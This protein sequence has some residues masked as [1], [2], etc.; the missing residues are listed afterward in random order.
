[1]RKERPILFNPQMVFAIISDRKTQTRRVA[2]LGEI[3][4]YP[5]TFVY[6]GNSRDID[7]AHP[8]KKY[9]TSP[10]FLLHHKNSNMISHIFQCPFGQIGD[11]LWVREVHYKYGHWEKNGK[12]KTGRQKWKFVADRS[13]IMY[14]DNPPSLF[15]KSRNKN[16]PEKTMCYKRL[17]RFMSKKDCRIRLKISQT[18]LERIRSIS[19][20]D[21]KSEGVY[22]APHRPSTCGEKLHSDKSISRDCFI[23]SFNLLWNRINGEAGFSTHKNPWVWVIHFERITV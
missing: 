13:A 6:V 10:W 9:D 3:S 4:D 22:M 5:D 19:Q 14:E 15:E 2:K 16:Y 17:A 11:V 1:M 7:V 8:A 12:T 20:E 23:C 21:A 18:K